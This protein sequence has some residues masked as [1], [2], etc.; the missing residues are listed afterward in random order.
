[1][2]A[3]GVL[4]ACAQFGAGQATTH[5]VKKA[6]PAVK[7]YT[8]N[9]RMSDV[10]TLANGISIIHVADITEARDALG[11]TRIESAVLTGNPDNELHWI[12]VYDPATRTKMA[13]NTQAKRVTV[14]TMPAPGSGALQSCASSNAPA[15][16]PVPPPNPAKDDVKREPLGTKTIFDVVATGVK[17]TRTV[18]TGAIG[19]DAP[20]VTVEE[21]WTAP[22][23]LSSLEQHR[24]S[25]QEGTVTRQLTSLTL[26]DPDPS[27]FT[28]PADYEVVQQEASAGCANS[29][30]TATPLPQSN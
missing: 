23:F 29:P 3:T 6:N 12:N 15:Q 11:R 14:T 21:N 7:S 16:P 9:Y 26:S 30:R 8:A 19:N 4:L 18:P 17:I 5:V 2:F 28:A 20:L 1:L 25:P 13:W 24:E 27:L 22:G 10:R